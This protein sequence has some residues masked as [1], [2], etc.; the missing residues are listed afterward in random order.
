MAI[1]SCCL[2]VLPGVAL[3]RTHLADEYAHANTK[4][5]LSVAGAMTSVT[6]NRGQEQEQAGAGACGS[7]RGAWWHGI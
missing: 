1:E 6:P 7:R 4:A 2:L 5:L 3:L